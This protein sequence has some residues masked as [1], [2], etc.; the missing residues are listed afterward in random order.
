MLKGK[1]S[2]TSYKPKFSGHETFPFRYL[3]VSKLLISIENH[4]SDVINNMSLLDLMVEFGVGAN[5]AK[6]IKHWGVVLGLINHQYELTE[7]GTVLLKQDKYLENPQTLWLIHWRIA[8][9]HELTTWFYVFNSLQAS[10]LKKEDLV[11]Q[12]SQ[13]WT[14]VSPNTI[15]RDIDCFI[16]MYTYGVN[17]KGLLSEDSLECPLAELNIINSTHERGIYE[18]QR[19]A[20]P[21]LSVEVFK[22]AL[23]EFCKSLNSATGLISFDTLLYGEASPAKIFCLPENILYQ[24]LE[25]IETHHHDIFKFTDGV[26]GLKQIQVV[27]DIDEKKFLNL[28]YKNKNNKKVAA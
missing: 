22:Y 18:I 4:G 8:S 11:E 7:F 9:N 27:S 25:E 19:G 12:F 5:M 13:I 16:R 26:G 10:R 24:Y 6:S 20:K 28:I 2:E 1:L 23:A 3:W 17:K 21:S 15:E 14:K